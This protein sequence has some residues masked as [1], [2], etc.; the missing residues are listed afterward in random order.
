MN[1]ETLLSQRRFDPTREM[2]PEQVLLSID[3]QNIGSIQNVITISGLPKQGKSRF[4]G[5]M[6]ASAITRNEIFNIRLRTPEGR[7]KIALFDTEQGEYD[8][9]KQIDFIKKLSGTTEMPENFF[10]YNTREDFPRTQIQ[11]VNK[12][13][14]L[15]KDCS[16]IFLDGILDLLDSFNDEKESMRLMRL[17]KKW[18]KEKN[19]LLIQVLHRRKDGTATLGHI[20]SAADRV[21]QSILTVEKNKERNTYILKPEYLRSAEDFTPIEIYYNRQDGGWQQT[22]FTPDEPEKIVRLKKPKPSELNIDD[23]RMN[24]LRIFNSQSLQN[25][26]ELRQNICEI[27]ATGSNWAQECVPYLI[28]QNLIYK[29]E[30]GYTNQRQGKLYAEKRS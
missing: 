5:A 26:K 20:G 7:N 14:E 19:I 27:Y 23:H 3:R 1:I 4:V 25:Y 16:V 18:T 9:Y 13:L 2:Q 8:F 22:W 6:I 30:G 21:S 11:L 12:F 28:S 24:V 17:I 10:A 15:N 29:V